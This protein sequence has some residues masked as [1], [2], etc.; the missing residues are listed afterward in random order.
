MVSMLLLL[1]LLLYLLLLQLSL[2]CFHPLL[3]SLLPLCGL[4]LE[5][6]KSLACIK[7]SRILKEKENE[8]KDSKHATKQNKEARGQDRYDTMMQTIIAVPTTLTTTAMMSL[9]DMRACVLPLGGQ[10]P[11]GELS[12]ASSTDMSG[13]TITTAKKENV[14]GVCEMSVR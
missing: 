14:Q 13:S 4:P 6:N 3:S 8:E 7:E 1:L 2:L 10:L 11:E 9:L 5:D 12:A